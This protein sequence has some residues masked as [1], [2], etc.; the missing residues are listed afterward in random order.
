M[1]PRRYRSP[2]E[3]VRLF[4]RHGGICHLCGCKIGIGQKWELSHDV[5]LELGGAD[6]DDNTKLAHKIC[7]RQQTSETDVPNIAKAKRR[8]ARH[9]GVKPDRKIR[10]WRN[11]NG[12]VVFAPRER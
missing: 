11:F 10:A 5:P 4:K 7:H 12:D 9:L 8:E 2:T 1:T 6:D 3:R